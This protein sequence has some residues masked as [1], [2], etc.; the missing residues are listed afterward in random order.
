MDTDV[1]CTALYVN[2]K[3]ARATLMLIEKPSKRDNYH[4]LK[5]DQY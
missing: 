3:E 5:V 4:W 2:N 1:K